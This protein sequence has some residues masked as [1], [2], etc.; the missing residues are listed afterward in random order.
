MKKE[1]PGNNR[2]FLVSHFVQKI[3]KLLSGFLQTKAKLENPPQLCY[4]P[5][6]CWQLW[7]QR[8]QVSAQAFICWSFAPNCSQS[9]A[10]R[11]HTSA[12]IPQVRLWKVEPRIIKLALV[13]Q[14]SAQSSKSRI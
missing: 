8:L 6:I 2:G 7:A 12:Q 4:I 14:I 11:W 1:I 13:A 10:Q 9:S 5:L 3:S